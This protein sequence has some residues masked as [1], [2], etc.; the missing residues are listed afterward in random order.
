MRAGRGTGT[1]K[2][3]FV[4]ENG[5]RD[6]SV[7]QFEGDSDKTGAFDYER[8][9]ANLWLTEMRLIEDPNVLE[10]RARQHAREFQESLHVTELREAYYDRMRMMKGNAINE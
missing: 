1:R 4:D 5:E 3:A 6:G 7:R 2:P 8:S 9:M 10:E